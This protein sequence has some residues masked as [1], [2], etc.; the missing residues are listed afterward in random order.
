M[1]RCRGYEVSLEGRSCIVAFQDVALAVRWAL[2]TQEDL[3]HHEWPEPIINSPDCPTVV[4]SDGRMLFR[5][6][7]ARM[8]RPHNNE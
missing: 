4:S 2:E 1:R 5:G 3:T 6:L 8:V 7:R